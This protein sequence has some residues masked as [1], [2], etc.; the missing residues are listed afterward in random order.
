MNNNIS[1]TGI[2]NT[3]T[4]KRLY[5]QIGSY[6]DN[7]GKV[8]RGTKNYNEILI[9]CNLVD[10][11][12]GNDFTDFVRILDKCNKSYQARCIRYNSGEPISLLVKRCTVDENGK[13][14]SNSNFVLNGVNIV[15]NDRKILPLF[16]YLA[17]LTN[18]IAVL[19]ET[20]EA[21]STLLKIANKSI[22]EESVR[23]IDNMI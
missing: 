11:K 15:P 21:Q 14:I 5:S 10:D 6:I 13:K 17:K 16:S 23:F 12:S 9:R 7:M 8:K 2:N 19:A 1:F 20:S 4:G 18:K 22:H 3:Y